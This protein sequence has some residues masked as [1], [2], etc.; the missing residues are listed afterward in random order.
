MEKGEGKKML[1]ILTKGREARG[2]VPTIQGK[3]KQPR[4]KK[5][6]GGKKGS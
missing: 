5:K 6:R 2:N 1:Q 4:S 3:K